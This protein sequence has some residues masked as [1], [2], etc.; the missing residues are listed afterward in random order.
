MSSKSS[1]HRQQKALTTDP[2]FAQAPDAA[3]HF[4]GWLQQGLSD[5]TLRVNQAGALVHFVDEGMLL[6]SPRIFREFAKNFGEVGGGPAS[7]PGE[8]DIGKIDPA[9]GP[10][11]RLASACRQG[12]QHPDLSGDARESRGVT[13]VRRSHS[14]SG[15]IRRPGSPQQ[16]VARALARRAGRRLSLW[17]TR[18]NPCCGPPTNYA[19]RLSHV[20]A[21][22]RC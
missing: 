3:R 1:R 8:P 10:A 9:P 17:A 21:R 6:V 13:T 14:Q 4:I 5:G 11:G 2:A 18:S 7:A 12:R 22:R 16:S 19:Q 15:A 20:L